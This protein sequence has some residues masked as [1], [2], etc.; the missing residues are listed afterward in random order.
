MDLGKRAQN[1]GCQL[2]TCTQTCITTLYKLYHYFL[3][4][5]WI[6]LVLRRTCLDRYHYLWSGLLWRFSMFVMSMVDNSAVHNNLE[7]NHNI[8]TF[9]TH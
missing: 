6:L 9:S 4:A 7:L 2:A 8:V 3:L 1:H 5:D